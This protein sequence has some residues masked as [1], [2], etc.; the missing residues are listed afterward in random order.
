MVNNMDISRYWQAVLTQDPDLMR[1]YFHKNAYINWHN[2][3]EH[4]TVDE[5]I[6]ANCEYPGDWDGEIERLE[7][8]GNLTITVAHVWAK[9]KEIS[10]HVTSFIQ[11]VDEKILEIDEYWS[12]D[13]IAPEWRKV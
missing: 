1:L 6:K 9:E 10:F 11:I 3:N 7:A 13:G 2:T 8:I 4:F 12:E 5:F